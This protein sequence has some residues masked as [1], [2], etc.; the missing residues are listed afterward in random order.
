ME[1]DGSEEISEKLSLWLNTQKRNVLIISVVINVPVQG[2]LLQFLHSSKRTL[3]GRRHRNLNRRRLDFTVVNI[4]HLLAFL[5]LMS[6]SSSVS[7]APTRCGHSQETLH[8]E[9]LLAVE[10][11]LCRDHYIFNSCHCYHGK[12]RK[13]SVYRTAAISLRCVHILWLPW[14]PA[15]W[16]CLH[17]ASDMPEGA[18]WCAFSP[19]SSFHFA[20]SE[21]LNFSITDPPAWLS[22]VTC[23]GPHRAQ[24]VT[25]EGIPASGLCWKPRVGC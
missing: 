25:E 8:Y 2:V 4:S 6:V 1:T 5:A 17:C 23:R 18:A 9:V 14:R 15:E 11:A 19:H 12:E 7:T 20:V 13:S 16:A 24:G 3:A 21:A 10:L 22:S